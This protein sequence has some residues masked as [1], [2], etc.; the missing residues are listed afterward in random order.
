MKSLL[1]SAYPPRPPHATLHS[2]R[3]AFKSDMDR[4]V[5]AGCDLF[6]IKPIKPSLLK[7]NVRMLLH[8]N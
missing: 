2:F 3:H 7:Q 6:K 5:E 4:A 8:I 1:E